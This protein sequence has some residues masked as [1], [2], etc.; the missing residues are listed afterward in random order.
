MTLHPTPAAAK[1]SLPRQRPQY[2]VQTLGGQLHNSL[3][4]LLHAYRH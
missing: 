3:Q 1:G 2:H 4:K